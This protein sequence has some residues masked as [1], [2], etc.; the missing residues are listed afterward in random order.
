M[1]LAT[2]EDLLP[3]DEEIAELSV[4]LPGRQVLRLEQAAHDRGLTAAQMIRRLIQEFLKRG[5]RSEG[6]PAHAAVRQWA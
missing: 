4:L 2:D 3:F 6:E 1:T 5:R